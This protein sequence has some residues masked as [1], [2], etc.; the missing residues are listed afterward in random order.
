ML[1]SHAFGRVAIMNGEL[2]KI[3]TRNHLE[4]FVLK[5]LVNSTS[6]YFKLLLR[7]YSILWRWYLF[8]RSNISK[9]SLGRMKN[10]WSRTAV[11]TVGIALCDFFMKNG[12]KW[13][14]CIPP[15]PQPPLAHLFFLS[16]SDGHRLIG[17]W[18]GGGRGSLFGIIVLFATKD[19]LLTSFAT[20]SNLLFYLSFIPLEQSFNVE[21][22]KSVYADTVG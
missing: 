13:S 4:F 8:S 1:L 10:H 5:R 17:D 15:P 18:V 6:A 20:F 14:W 7:I 21:K 16:L 3:W 9:Y 12:H 2:Q 19:Y 11:F 22:T